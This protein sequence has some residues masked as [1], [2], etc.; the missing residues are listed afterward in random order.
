MQ[1]Y[2]RTLFLMLDGADCTYSTHKSYVNRPTFA[3]YRIY[4]FELMPWLISVLG[5]MYTFNAFFFL[6]KRVLSFREEKK[7]GDL[8]NYLTV[9]V[10]PIILRWLN[11][12]KENRGRLFSWKQVKVVR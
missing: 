3:S 6:R 1:I 7:S 10:V 9:A 11:V 5:G 12:G 8:R 4:M 2:K